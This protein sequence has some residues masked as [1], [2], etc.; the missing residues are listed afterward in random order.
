MKQVILFL[1]VFS[2]LFA[3]CEKDP[4]IDKGKLDPNAM[5]TIRPAA[6]TRATISGLTGLEVVE[7]ANLI[8]YQSHYF[9]NQYNDVPK[10][11][12]RAFNEHQKDFNIPALLMLG[13][14]VIDYQGDYYRDFTNGF[15]MFITD[16]NDDTIAY[17]PDH[18]INTARPLIEQAYADENF[19][20]VYRLFDEAFTFIPIE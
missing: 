16:V 4:V 17:I 9:S 3:G 15:N 1:S 18:V 6:S 11:I 2:L 12:E 19:A 8:K 14:D 7:E 5:I 13:T 10:I 20:E